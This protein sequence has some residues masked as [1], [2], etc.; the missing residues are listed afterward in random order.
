MGS[1]S[2]IAFPAPGRHARAA[3]HTNAPWGT[4]GQGLLFPLN[5]MCA[6]VFSALTAQ[7]VQIPYPWFTGT[8]IAWAAEARSTF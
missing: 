3:A 5:L 6:E 8:G 2:A 4:M 7:A 1:R